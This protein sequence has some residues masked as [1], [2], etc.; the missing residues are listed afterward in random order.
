MQSTA[1]EL[2]AA[3]VRLSPHFSH[4]TCKLFH[5]LR[6]PTGPGTQAC[7]V[8]IHMW[9]LVSLPPNPVF[10]PSPSDWLGEWKAKH[11]QTTQAE[12]ESTYPSR[13]W[14]AFKTT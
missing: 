13:Q 9:L 12:A 7:L 3:G 11:P 14:P 8:D 1:T 4:F 6:R 10:P 5:K 2:G